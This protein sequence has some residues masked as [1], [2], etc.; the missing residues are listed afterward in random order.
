MLFFEWE[1]R[2]EFTQG[3]MGA[4]LNLDALKSSHPIEVPIL[5]AHN[6]DEVFDDITYRKGASIIRMLAEYT[7]EKSFQKVLGQYL[8]ANAYKNATTKNLWQFLEKSSGKPVER[9]MAHGPM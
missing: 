4:A 9:V 1:Y 2:E 3:D 6:I 5:D 7:G 8:K